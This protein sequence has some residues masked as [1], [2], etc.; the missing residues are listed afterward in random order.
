M[1]YEFQANRMYRMPTH[2]GPSLGPRQGEA[3]RKFVNLESPKVTSWSVNF[4]TN[5][6]QLK[7]LLPSGFELTGEPVVTVEATYITEIEWLAGRGYNTLGVSF[8]AVFHGEKDHAIGSFLAVLWENLTDP[9]LTG[10][11]ELGFAKIYSEIP[12]ARIYQGQTHIITSWMDFKFMDL[13]ISNLK[14]LVPE[15]IDVFMGQKTGDGILHYKYI[16]KTGELGKPDACYATLTPAVDIRRVIK[17]IWRGEGTVEFH[18]A[19]WEALP[20]MFSIVNTLQNL[21][22]EEYRGALM[23]KTVGSKDLS[24]TRILR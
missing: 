11:E 15:E 9:I 14:Q 16:P 7:K 4:L 12:E 10:R 23:I 20:T 13:K 8:P 5:C 17:E 6:E 21:A 3:G 24:D 19:T 2:F 1:P 18:K 22:I